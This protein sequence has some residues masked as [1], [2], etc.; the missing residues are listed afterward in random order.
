MMNQLGFEADEIGT[1]AVAHDRMRGFQFNAGDQLRL[2]SDLDGNRVT[3]DAGES[4][5]A[6][7]DFLRR[8]CTGG[9]FPSML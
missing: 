6:R 8:C 2:D 1:E 4:F 3:E 9:P 5:A 7:L